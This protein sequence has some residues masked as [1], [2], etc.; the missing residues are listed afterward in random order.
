MAVSIIPPD[1][2]N[3]L[4]FCS[5]G[6]GACD[7]IA[8]E[9]VSD[10][11][12]IFVK[13]RDEAFNNTLC[14]Q[15]RCYRMPFIQGDT[16]QL[17]T[18]FSDFYNIDPNDPQQ[19][20]GT[21]FRVEAYD[22]ETDALI[23]DNVAVIASRYLAGSVNN[24][25]YQLIEINTGLVTFANTCSF[26]L[27]LMAMDTNNEVR[28]ELYTQEWERIYHDCD[29][30]VQIS[31]NYFPGYDCYGNY[32]GFPFNF[33]GEVGDNELA[34]LYG[35]ANVQDGGS[36]TAFGENLIPPGGSGTAFGVSYA[37][38]GLFAYNPTFRVYGYVIDG[39]DSI[40]KTRSGDTITSV[41]L[42]R[43]YNLVLSRAVPYYV[44][45]LLSREA[46]PAPGLWIDG[47]AYR[48]D[49]FTTNAN[50]RFGRF[51]HFDITMERLCELSV[52]C[53]PILRNRTNGLEI[54]TNLG[55]CCDSC[56][57]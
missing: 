6:A 8:V 45:N 23:S 40:V 7:L 44:K 39:S 48:M 5:F 3:C 27:R 10:D 33:S 1:I 53:Q 49:N 25:S 38:T 9:C 12:T 15:D 42:V 56:F 28:Q 14:Q 31:Y 32:Y 51:W 29:P 55:D 50:L 18:R 34:I 41:E 19:G 24:K 30:T 54:G 17:Q 35:V 37:G 21:A 13:S 22:A 52:G 57:G 46:F 26:Y 47:E 16:I 20:W 2:N 11:E 36:G 43:G 4:E